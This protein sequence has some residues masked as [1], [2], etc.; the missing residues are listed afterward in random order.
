MWAE[1]F[2]LSPPP[3]EKLE[4]GLIQLS[5]LFANA[6]RDPKKGSPF[7]LSD[8]NLFKDPFAAQDEEEEAG[9]DGK[10]K[11]GRYTEAEQK[12]MA[13]LMEQG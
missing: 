1:M 2:S 6:N 3:D 5:T 8:L 9:L 13:A 12:T 11:G 4:W 10:P 7:K